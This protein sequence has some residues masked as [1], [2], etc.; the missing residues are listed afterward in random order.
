MKDKKEE[1][2]LDTE[3]KQKELRE[4]LLE[5]ATKKTGADVVEQI[6][7][8]LDARKSVSRTNPLI[9]RLRDKNRLEQRDAAKQREGDFADVRVVGGEEAVD[10]IFEHYG[11]NPTVDTAEEAFSTFSVDVDT[12]SYAIA[13]ANLEQGAL[14]DP[15]AVRVEELV[16]NFRYDYPPPKS[17]PFSVVAEAFPSPNRKGYHLLLLGLKGKVIEES[18][19]PPANLVFVVDVSGSMDMDNRLGSVKRAL[20]LLIDKMREDDTVAIVTYGDVASVVLEPTS[21][22]QKERIRGALSRLT[23][24]GST[25]AQAGICSGTRSRSARSTGG[26]TRTSRAA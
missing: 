24:S 16:N 14:P 11:T 6:G 1:N 3:R 4:R 10:R 25:N 23:P 18:A 5:D 15:A 12:A 17:E 9:E 22:A 2:V 26:R 7:A 20:N 21:G 8:Y 19:R 13:R